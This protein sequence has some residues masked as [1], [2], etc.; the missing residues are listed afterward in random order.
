MTGAA[1]LAGEPLG[2]LHIAP[3]MAYEYVCHKSSA[4]RAVILIAVCHSLCS[5]V[6]AG[7]ECLPAGRKA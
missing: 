7:L 3:A 5:I 6:N 1:N 2:L 4:N